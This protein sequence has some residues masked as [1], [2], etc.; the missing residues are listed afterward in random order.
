MNTQ[1]H[2]SSTLEAIRSAFAELRLNEMREQL[3]R[4]LADAPPD[5]DT[6][7]EF[8]WRLLD[9]QV[10]ARRERAVARRIH[11]AKLPA[12]KTLDGFDFDFQPELDRERVLQLATMDFV[13]KGQNILFA[14]ASGTGKSHLSIALG[15]LA[16]VAGYRT[17]YTTSAAMLATL[18]ASLASESLAQAIRP[19]LKVQLLIIDEVGLDAPERDRARDAHLFYRVIAPRYEKRS[20]TII[21]SNIDWDAWGEYLG[22]DV[23]TVAIL[24]RLVHHGHLITINDGPSYRAAEHDKLNHAP[25]HEPVAD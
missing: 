25:E 16:C 5:G 22:D 14:G 3:D 6:R 21:T 20:S 4:E 7:T 1:D 8:L 18:H 10:R 17:F 23:A 12:D 24:D 9:A 13:R 2:P 11:A 15:H 19:Y